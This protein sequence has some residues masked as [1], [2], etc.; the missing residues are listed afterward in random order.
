MAFVTIFKVGSDLL[1][2]VDV[3]LPKVA[4]ILTQTT[5]KK[6]LVVSPAD[7][8]P[9]VLRTLYK[10]KQGKRPKVNGT[11]VNWKSF[12]AEGIAYAGSTDTEYERDRPVVIVHTGGTTGKPK[13]VLLTNENLNA[14]TFQAQLS[15]IDMQRE[16]S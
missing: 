8:L 11:C 12:I 5:I 7:S 15:G 1:I 14:S 2:I 3:A 10:I 4:D 16:H 13:G 9:P 6:V